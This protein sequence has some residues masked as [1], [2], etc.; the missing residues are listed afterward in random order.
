MPA[1]RINTPDKDLAEKTFH[2]IM[3]NCRFSYLPKSIYVISERDYEWIENK[4]LPI[5][6]LDEEEVKKSVFEFKKE[7]G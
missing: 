5:E 1:I 7:K 3:K 6:V 4:G 2:T